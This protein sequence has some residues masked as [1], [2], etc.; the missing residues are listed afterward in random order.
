MG[1]NR[2]PSI[3]IP[4]PKAAFKSFLRSQ[5]FD[6]DINTASLGDTHEHVIANLGCDF[7]VRL[8]NYRNKVQMPMAMKPA[9]ANI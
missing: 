3:V 9:P 5:R 1:P 7:D 6:S 8:M 4:I 2:L